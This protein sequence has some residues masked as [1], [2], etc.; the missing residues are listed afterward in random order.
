MKTG[1]LLRVRRDVS[2]D[3]GNGMVTLTAPPLRLTLGE[4]SPGVREAVHRLLDGATEDEVFDRAVA[5]DGFVAVPYVTHLLQR[6]EASG[7]LCRTIITDHGP[8]A[9]V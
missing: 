6:M 1:E 5:R 3:E 9:T 2:L 4:V 7:I 8:L